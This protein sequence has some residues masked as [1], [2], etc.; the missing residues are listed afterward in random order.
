MEAIILILKHATLSR[1]SYKSSEAALAQAE[2]DYCA[3]NIDSKIQQFLATASSL[4]LS[5]EK[6]ASFV[7]ATDISKFI[8][9]HEPK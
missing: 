5:V 8:F 2:K 6:F 3:A 4:E 7:M 9:L 1:F